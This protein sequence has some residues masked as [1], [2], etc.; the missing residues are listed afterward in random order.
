MEWGKRRMWGRRVC[1]AT[2]SPNNNCSLSPTNVS[3]IEGRV[4][5]LIMKSSHK[6]RFATGTGANLQ[7]K[8]VSGESEARAHKRTAGLNIDRHVASESAFLA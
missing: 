5:T 6:A 1:G 8:P 3:D 7:A 2:G 4:E